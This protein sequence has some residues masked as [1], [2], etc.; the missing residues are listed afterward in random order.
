MSGKEALTIPVLYWGLDHLF[1]SYHKLTCLAFERAVRVTVRERRYECYYFDRPIVK[2]MIVGI[3]RSREVKKYKLWL[4]IDDGSAVVECSKY[5]DDRWQGEPYPEVQVG[6]IVSV[7]GAVS[8][9]K[10]FYDTQARKIIA[11]HTARL[12]VHPDAESRHMREAI[13]LHKAFYSQPLVLP[14][15]TQKHFA[16]AYHLFQEGC[17]CPCGCST[18]V[19]QQL[20]YCRCVGHW[21]FSSSTADPKG[22]FGA[23][24]LEY[25]LSRFQVK[26]SWPFSILYYLYLSAAV[27]DASLCKEQKEQNSRTSRMR[28]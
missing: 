13:L 25:L 10:Y 16:N 18:E 15:T 2:V 22:E 17:G 26:S 21:A 8:I 24:I 28:A 20:L 9:F 23:W 1:F 5:Y 6:D 4:Q 19:R 7:Q 27:W 12:E 3:V 14:L 11:I